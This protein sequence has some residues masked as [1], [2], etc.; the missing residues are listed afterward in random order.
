MKFK[1]RA[2]YTVCRVPLAL[3]NKISLEK[4]LI[5]SY[6]ENDQIMA[7]IKISFLKKSLVG[8]H[9]KK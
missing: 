1:E 2:I 6:G 3:S 9:S 8:L 4:I 7:D 5:T